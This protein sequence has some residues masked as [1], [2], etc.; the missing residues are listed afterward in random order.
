MSS[1]YQIYNELT[2]LFLIK[3]HSLERSLLANEFKFDLWVEK[4]N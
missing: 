4:R 3:M 1:L 2:F